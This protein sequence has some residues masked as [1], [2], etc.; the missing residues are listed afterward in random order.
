MPMPDGQFRF[1]RATDR[2][3][4]LVHDLGDRNHTELDPFA[5]GK[6]RHLS[7]VSL[8]V[9]PDGRSLFAMM[10]VSGDEWPF[11]LALFDLAEKRCKARQKSLFFTPGGAASA[12]SPDGAMVAYGADGGFAVLDVADLK[13]RLIAGGNS[14]SSLAFSPDGQRLAVGTSEGWVELWSVRAA[15]Q[16]R[17]CGTGWGMAG[18]SSTT[19]GGALA[20]VRASGVRT[21]DLAGT[22]ERLALGGHRGG[23]S[24]VD[25]S[26]DGAMLASTGKDGVLR[27]WD[28]A[29][30][31]AIRALEARSTDTQGCAVQARRVLLAFG[32]AVGDGGLFVY[33]TRDWSPVHDQ[34]HL[35]VDSVRFSRDGT[36]LATGTDDAAIVHRV[37][38]GAGGAPTLDVETRFPVPRRSLAME[39]SPDGRLV[40]Y[41]ADDTQI[42]VAEVGFGGLT[43]LLV[44]QADGGLVRDRLPL[45]QG[46]GL[47]GRGRPSRG[48]GRCGRPPGP[49]D[50]RA[51]GVRRLHL[52][53]E[54]RR[55][56]AG[57]PGDA[58]LGRDG[59]PGARR[60]RVDVPAERSAVWSLGFSPDGRR[61]A[62]GTA[63]GELNLWDLARVRSLL[64]GIAAEVRPASGPN[65]RPES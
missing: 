56:V 14:A 34:R 31:R 20:S 7:S 35:K 61:L 32:S 43:D 17:R 22:P 21:W 30:G 54:R 29:T 19:A 23:V 62:V 65:G 57:H 40:A 44:P 59:G 52:G 46:A 64:E 2:A 63:D 33:R 51:R 41:V 25:F 9:S 47:R 24:G 1:W 18:W 36:R 55:P 60:C 8:R 27:I 58:G 10:E 4:F 37:R 26:P 11:Q 12:F 39:F 45:R 48:L 42:R 38:E 50:W 6:H 15:H 3:T 49:H 28:P 53:G 5:D 13:P 16:L